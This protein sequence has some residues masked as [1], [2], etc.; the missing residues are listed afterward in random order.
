MININ[1][2]FKLYYE[3]WKNIDKFIFIL[4]LSM[5]LLGLFF[6][7]VS[8]VL[9]CF[10][11]FSDVFGRVRTRSDVQ[12]CSEV[13]GRFRTFW[14][15]VI[16]FWKFS[17]FLDVFVIATFGVIYWD[18]WLTFVNSPDKIG[19]FQ[20]QYFCHYHSLRHAFWRM[21]VQSG[22]G[23]SFQQ[24]I[25][26]YDLG[27]DETSMMARL[28][29]LWPLVHCCFCLTCDFWSCLFSLSWGLVYCVCSLCI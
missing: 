20:K 4:I 13:F 3:W 25:A 24:P 12:M 11:T 14:E 9:N 18:T 1:T 10:R 8:V 16:R 23:K 17:E 19:A 27:G 6:L 22:G 26:V 29:D 28:S 2:V 7:L 5:F 15:D 21:Y